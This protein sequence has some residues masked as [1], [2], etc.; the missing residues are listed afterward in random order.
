MGGL[1]MELIVL[2]F[3]VFMSKKTQKGTDALWYIKGLKKDI[4]TAEHCRI[5]FREEKD[6]F[7][8]FLSYA[9]IFDLANKPKYLKGL[10]ISRLV[11]IDYPIQISLSRKGFLLVV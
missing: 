6:L 4:K 7:E 3:A 2:I 10:L 5:R 9:V 1:V 8:K 11:G